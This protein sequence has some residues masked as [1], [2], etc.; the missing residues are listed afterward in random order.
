MTDN[1]T[2]DS[3]IKASRKWEEKNRRKATIGGYKRVARLYIRKHAE[4]EDLKELEKLI[5]ERRKNI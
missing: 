1:K 4:E 2:S 5:K 3:Q